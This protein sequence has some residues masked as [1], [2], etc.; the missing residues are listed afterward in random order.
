[1]AQGGGIA[2]RGLSEANW[3]FEVAGKLPWRWVGD[4][5]GIAGVD[6]GGGGVLGVRTETALP[7]IGNVRGGEYED[8]YSRRMTLLGVRI[9]WRHVIPRRTAVVARAGSSGRRGA[10]HGS[11]QEAVLGWQDFT[12]S[13]RVAAGNSGLANPQRCA[14]QREEIGAAHGGVAWKRE[15]GASEGCMGPGRGQRQWVAL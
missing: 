2:S 7:F 3:S 15:R 4:E 11:Q 13:T 12:Y 9:R 10:G 1:M 8:E 14:H 5:Q 6:G